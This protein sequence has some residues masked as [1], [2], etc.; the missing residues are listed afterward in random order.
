MSVRKTSFSAFRSAATAAAA[1]SALTFSQPPAASSASDGMTGTTPAAAKSA[2]EPGVDARHLADAA[3]VD[4]F[5]R[6]IRRQREPFAEQ[7]LQRAGVQADGPAA[8]LADLRG[9]CR[10]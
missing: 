2:I 3:E 10:R 6:R 1:V 4:R 9:R 5:G 7:G 8:E